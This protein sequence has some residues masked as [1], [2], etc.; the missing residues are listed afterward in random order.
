MP[1]NHPSVDGSHH[2]PSEENPKEL[3]KWIGKPTRSRW[4]LFPFTRSRG[5]TSSCPRTPTQPVASGNKALV[6]TD[7]GDWLKLN[8]RQDQ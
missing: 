3:R 5:R 6:I 1:E 8:V 4:A 7:P 2:P